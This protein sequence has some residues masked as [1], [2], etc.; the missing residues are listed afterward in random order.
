MLHSER[1]FLHAEKRAAQFHRGGERLLAALGRAVHHADQAR[2]VDLRRALQLPRPGEAQAR[3]VGRE[4]NEAGVVQSAATGP[5]KHLQELV[6]LHL[7][8][9]IS[10]E[11]T[12]VSDEDRAHGKVDA[13]RQ[14]H[15][16]DDNVELSAFASGST[17]PARTA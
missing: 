2:P 9:K 16:R 14:S 15:R 1:H 13:R 4:K 11:I 5:A 7:A 6:R 12:G 17:N 10:R 8:L 3:L